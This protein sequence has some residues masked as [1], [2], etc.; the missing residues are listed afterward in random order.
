VVLVRSG[1]LS[2][3]LG[4]FDDGGRDDIAVRAGDAVLGE[5]AGD[6]DFE[7][8]F[9]AEGDEGY[10]FGGDGGGDVRFVVGGEQAVEF[11]V[12]AMVAVA[13]APVEPAE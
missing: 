2:S 11:V 5:F 6:D 12:E 10:F 8:V 9:Q 7:L 4:G 3:G 13:V 1:Y